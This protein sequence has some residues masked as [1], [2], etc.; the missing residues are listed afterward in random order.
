MM[1]M[2]IRLMMMVQMTT[3]KYLTIINQTWIKWLTSMN[4]FGNDKCIK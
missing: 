1:L 4:R 3:M 2:M